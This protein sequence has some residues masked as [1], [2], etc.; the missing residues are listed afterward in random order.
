M[1]KRKPINIDMWITV[2]KMYLDIQTVIRT[3]VD[4]QYSLKMTE[5]LAPAPLR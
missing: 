4:Y 3:A 2:N 1:E 5:N